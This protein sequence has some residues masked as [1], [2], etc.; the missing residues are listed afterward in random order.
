MDKPV[1]I[2]TLRVGEPVHLKLHPQLQREHLQVGAHIIPLGGEG[3]DTSKCREHNEQKG[4]KQIFVSHNPVHW[5]VVAYN[6]SKG[7]NIF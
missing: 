6:N 1:M 4:Y 5:Q 2:T 3:E 7:T